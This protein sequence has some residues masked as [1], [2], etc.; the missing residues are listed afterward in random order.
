M[1]TSQERDTSTSKISL[2][3][4]FRLSLIHQEP[5]LLTLDI[6]KLANKKRTDAYVNINHSLCSS[7]KEIRVQGQVSLREI[8]KEQIGATQS[9]ELD[10][11]PRMMLPR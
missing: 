4:V 3:I 10:S 6:E 9:L 11:R 7:R 8:H 1:S 2:F 5:P